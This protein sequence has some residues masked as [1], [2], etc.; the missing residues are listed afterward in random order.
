MFCVEWSTRPDG[1]IGCLHL[2]ILFKFIPGII[3]FSRRE[4]KSRGIKSEPMSQLQHGIA[5]LD[6]LL[7]LWKMEPAQLSESFHFK[8]N[9]DAFAFSVATENAKASEFC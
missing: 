7:S 9:S 3:L 4:R 2:N 8:Q 5:R 1:E 6:A